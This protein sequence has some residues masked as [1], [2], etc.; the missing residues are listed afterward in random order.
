[1]CMQMNMCAQQA[2]YYLLWYY[3]AIGTQM[4]FA[5]NSCWLI[6][7][8][9]FSILLPFCYCFVFVVK[10]STTTKTV[11]EKDFS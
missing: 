1:M 3:Y 9:W 7:L 2:K 6:M 11:L 5:T 8:Y 10:L 4:K